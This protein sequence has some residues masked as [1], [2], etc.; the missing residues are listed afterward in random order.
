LEVPPTL[1]PVTIALLLESTTLM[2][3]PIEPPLTVIA[4]DAS[5]EDMRVATL[6]GETPPTPLSAPCSIFTLPLDA[7]A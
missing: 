5:M 6:L 4:P 1:P 2:S 3:P 7:T